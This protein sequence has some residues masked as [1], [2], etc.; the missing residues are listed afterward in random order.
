MDS[1]DNNMLE[2]KKRRLFLLLS[3][4]QIGLLILILLFAN[5]KYEVSDDFMMEMV[6]SGAYTGQPDP[7]IMFSNIILGWILSFF[8]RIFPNVS[9]FFLGQ[10]FICLYSYLAITYILTHNLKPITATLILILLVS[11][12]ARDFYILPQFTKTAIAASMSGLSL[13]IWGVF[14]RKKWQI[15]VLGGVLALLGALVRQKAFYIAVAYAGIYAIYKSV[16]VLF[17]KKWKIKDVITR[18]W[19]PG[20]ILL[21]LVFTCG[22]VDDFS[23]KAESDYNYYRE[24]SKVR[25]QIVDYTWVSYGECQEA[26]EKIGI[27]ENDYNMILGWDFA[28]A[29]A[30]SLEKMNQ[31]LDVVKIYRKNYHPKIMDAFRMIKD[32]QLHYAIALCC[33]ILG[34]VCIC[35]NWRRIW[36]PVM[37]A[38]ITGGFLVY[39]YCLGRW[40]YRVE[41]G[42]FYCAAIL[43]ICFCNLSFS[44]K[45][46]NI[47]LYAIIVI[48]SFL[49]AP[50]Y[51]LNQNW[52]N[53]DTS[54]YRALVDNIFYYSWNYDPAKYPT[55]VMPVKIRPAF[56]SLINENTDNLYLL[57]FNTCIQTFYYDFSVFQSSRVSFPKNVFYFAGVTEYHPSVQAYLSER[58]CDNLMNALLKDNVYFVSNDSE[59]MILQFFQEHGKKNVHMLFVNEIDGYQIWKYVEG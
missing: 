3:V 17:Y 53:M 15:C 42:F 18:A 7:H 31:V 41:F 49:Q 56:L 10:M 57:D 14:R 25:S 52:K 54:E 26:F 34:I 27:S 22:K 8:Y 43:I 19:F 59:K 55:V 38:S 4:G 5:V 11:F 1:T 44:N 46:L 32:R 6:A 12:T 30:F 48:A 16:C 9:W 29:K 36:L 35:L 45:H 50:Y 40:V 33:M 58:Q 39:F 47:G 28:D 37:A 13:L 24:F 23:Y 51:M 21:L 20:I 2:E